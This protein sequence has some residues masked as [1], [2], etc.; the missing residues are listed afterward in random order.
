M[1]NREEGKNIWVRRL[2][3]SVMAACLILVIYSSAQG[4]P[5]PDKPGL[6]SPAD[7]ATGVST[8]PTLDWTD[9]DG[10][11]SYD[12][13][14]CNDTGC[15][16]IARSTKVTASQWTVSPALNP[17]TKYGWRARAKNSYGYGSWSTVR[18]FTTVAPVPGV[19]GLVSPAAGATGVW[20]TPTL[21]WSDVDGATSYDVQVCNDT[22]GGRERIILM[23]PGPGVLFGCLR[24]V[25]VILH[26][27]LL[28]ISKEMERPMSRFMKMPPVTGLCTTPVIRLMV[29]KLLA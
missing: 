24:R 21:D 14:V 26:R 12:V 7:G 17:L 20:M 2:A 22:V 19:P 5:L 28:L 1:S 4:Y 18:S 3:A 8:T 13:Q 6:V 29:S 10:A 11:T 15:A 16:D 23:G 25:V 9:V 27:S